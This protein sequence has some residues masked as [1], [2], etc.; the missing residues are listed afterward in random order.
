MGEDGNDNDMASA[1]K[2]HLSIGVRASLRY[3]SALSSNTVIAATRNREV[4]FVCVVSLWFVLFF[5]PKVVLQ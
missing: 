3:P 5:V 2:R 4:V 1:Y